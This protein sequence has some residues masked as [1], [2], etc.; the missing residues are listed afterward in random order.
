MELKELLDI[1]IS[2]GW[3]YDKDRQI[4]YFEKGG[5]TLVIFLWNKMNREKIY[6]IISNKGRH[7]IA[8]NNRIKNLIIQEACRYSYEKGIPVVIF[9]S[10]ASEFNK[11]G[12][13]DRVEIF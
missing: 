6:E 3:K 11:K 8:A 12:K 4:V 2:S 13:F 5:K 1:F 10:T 9:V 7:F